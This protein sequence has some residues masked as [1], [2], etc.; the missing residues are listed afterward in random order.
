M[1][2]TIDTTGIDFVK[3]NQAAAAVR[4]P[5]DWEPPRVLPNPWRETARRED[6]AAYLNAAASLICILSCA[7]EQDDQAWLHLSVSHRLR[8]PTWGEMRMCKDLFLGDRYAVSI[9][10][11]QAMYININSKVLHLFALLDVA[12]QPS[13]PDFSRG[14]G[15]I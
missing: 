7:Y 8:I 11:P 3:L 4:V 5:I 13:L 1:N 12:A 10:P 9:L 15:S 6:G 14:V 2:Q